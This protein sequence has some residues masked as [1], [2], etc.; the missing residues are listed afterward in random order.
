MIDPHTAVAASVY[1]EYREKTHDG[2]KTVIASTASPFKFTR[3]VMAAIDPKYEDMDDFALV[4]ELSRISC[5]PVPRAVEESRTAPVLHR[6]E[7]EKDGM[8]KAVEEFL[9]LKA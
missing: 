9:G 2:R 4:D 6:I 8:K 1:D 3:S 7:C 5:V